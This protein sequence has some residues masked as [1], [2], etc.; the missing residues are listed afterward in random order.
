MRLGVR[1][2][3][4]APQ[5]QHRLLIKRPGRKELREGCGEHRT[6]NRSG[7]CDS[8]QTLHWTLATIEH[9]FCRGR[10]PQ[11]AGMASLSAH[12]VLHD[13]PALR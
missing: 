2:A 13:D 7:S 12:E 6:R 8:S 5:A 10:F 4:I 3:G 11:I 1:L 9:M